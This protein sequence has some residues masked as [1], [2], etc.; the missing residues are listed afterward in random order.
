MMPNTPTTKKAKLNKSAY[1][2]TCDLAQAAFEYEFLRFL[3]RL[4]RRGFA[5]VVD[6]DAVSVRFMTQ[7][8]AKSGADLRQLGRAFAVD[9]ACGGG[10]GSRLDPFGGGTP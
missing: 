3:R 6:S 5:L 10:A 1:G 4:H 7:E 9:N 8:Q 2:P